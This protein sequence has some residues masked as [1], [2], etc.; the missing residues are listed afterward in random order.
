[1]HTSHWKWGVKVFWMAYLAAYPYFPLGEWPHW[2]TRIP[3][4]GPFIES[5]LLARDFEEFTR[6]AGESTSEDL[7][8]QRDELWEEFCTVVQVLY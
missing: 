5:Q 3:M 6:K 7:M 1:Q 8:K 2:D 4:A